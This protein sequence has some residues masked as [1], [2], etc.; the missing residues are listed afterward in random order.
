MAFGKVDAMILNIASASYYIAKDGITNL[1][2]T[3]DT[4]FIFDLS[5]AC[6]NDW[7]LLQSILSKGLATITPQERKAILDDWI[8]LGKKGWTPSPTFIVN[9]IVRIS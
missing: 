7:P 9:R 8:S 6:R 4:N 3:E 1:K 5:F 2:V